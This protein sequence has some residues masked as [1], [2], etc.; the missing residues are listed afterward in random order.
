MMRHISNDSVRIPPSLSGHQDECGIPLPTQDAHERGSK[1]TSE[2]P[3]DHKG[4]PWQHF[5]GPDDSESVVSELIFRLKESISEQAGSWWRASMAKV[6]KRPLLASYETAPEE[7][8][9]STHEIQDEL[10]PWAFQRVLTL[11]ESQDSRSA[12]QLRRRLFERELALNHE[13]GSFAAAARAA[14]VVLLHSLT[15]EERSGSSEKLKPANQ[16]RQQRNGPAQCFIRIRPE[17][18]S[19]L[20]RV[21]QPK[22]PDDEVYVFDSLV[23]TVVVGDAQAN[24]KPHF[25]K[26]VYQNDVKGRQ[27]VADAVYATAFARK[28]ETDLRL[29]SRFH[30]Q[31]EHHRD[32]RQQVDTAWNLHDPTKFERAKLGLPIA[33]LVD[34]A[35]FAVLVEPLLPL[36]P[37]PVNVLEELVADIRRC[38]PD[39]VQQCGNIGSPLGCFDALDKVDRATYH[40]FKNIAGFLNLA[41]YPFPRGASDFDMPLPQAALW[42]SQVDHFCIFR[43]LHETLPPKCVNGRVVP[44]QRFRQAFLSRVFDAALPCTSREQHRA[45]EIRASK[46]VQQHTPLRGTLEALSVAARSL[47]L[48]IKQDVVPAINA[49]QKNFLDSH[50][51]AHALHTHGINIRNMAQLLKN[52]PA[53]PFK[54]AIIREVVARSAKHL[55]RLQVEKL[56]GGGMV[57]T[58]HMEEIQRYKV[59]LTEM[60]SPESVCTYSLFKAMEYNLNADNDNDG[61]DW[62][63]QLRST[64]RRMRHFENADAYTDQDDTIKLR[65]PATAEKLQKFAELREVRGFYPRVHLVAPETIAL[66]QAATASTVA[67]ASSTSLDVLLDNMKAVDEEETLHELI[68]NAADENKPLSSLKQCLRYKRKKLAL[69]LALLSKAAIGTM[70]PWPMQ[71]QQTAYIMLQHNEIKAAASIADFIY[72]KVPDG[73]SLQSEALLIDMQCTTRGNEPQDALLCYRNLKPVLVAMEGKMSLRLLLADLLLASFA[74]KNKRYN[75]AILH[76][77]RVHKISTV[78]FDTGGA[79]WAAVAALRLIA[80]SMLEV[81]RCSEAIII[82]QHTVRVASTNPELPSLVTHMSR[83]W[84]AAAF[85]RMGR[86]ENATVE[87][88]SMLAGLESQLGTN[89]EATMSALYLA[90]EV[91]MRLGCLSLQNPPLKIGGPSEM[92]DAAGIAGAPTELQEPLLW[93][94]LGAEDFEIYEELFRDQGMSQARADAEKLFL[95]LFRR[96]LFREDNV[97]VEV[98]KPRGLDRKQRLRQIFS[99]L[100]QILKLKLCSIPISVLR[101]LAHRIYVAC[102]AQGCSA[103]LRPFGL[104]E[105]EAVGSD[106]DDAK[107]SSKHPGYAKVQLAPNEEQ[108]YPF[109]F[110]SQQKVSGTERRRAHGEDIL[111]ARVDGSSGLRPA[112]EHDD[113]MLQ[114]LLFGKSPTSLNG[115]LKTCYMSY[116]LEYE[117]SSPRPFDLTIGITRCEELLNSTTWTGS[118]LQRMRSQLDFTLSKQLLTRAGPTQAWQQS[119]GNSEIV[120]GGRADEDLPPRANAAFVQAGIASL[121]KNYIELPAVGKGSVSGRTTWK[122]MSTAARLSQLRFGGT[123]Q[124]IANMPPSAY[125]VM[126]NILTP[127]HDS[128]LEAFGCI[129]CLQPADRVPFLGG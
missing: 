63:T 50:D 100:K 5:Q 104:M 102:V 9:E 107:G 78:C 67:G 92:A 97:L 2:I 49:L 123:K 30:A 6:A 79:H 27:A 46:F 10:A 20:W 68:M 45:T 125:G 62:G 29:Q 25:A 48:A 70:L 99:T 80:R 28:T 18:Y 58:S 52:G 32:L 51:I 86:L 15:L 129:E 66:M 121:E 40:K 85:A 112:Q 39:F 13:I 115:V 1:A 33:C 38:L 95:A 61:E 72:S 73:L 119:S 57:D 106:G 93:K 23:L 76:A 65:A 110:F 113:I 69:T 98:Y 82:L 116:Y 81:Q 84:L 11:R 3:L 109:S 59:D 41:D 126:G 14:A 91:K 54:D 12:S 90:A 55:F 34:Y 120:E 19:T 42:R 56:A 96:L 94:P 17:E 16:E 4:P 75:S 74:F 128:E 111:Y 21:Y 8:F 36:N 105:Q 47:E 71:L 22:F 7:V 77:F 88:Q 101:L 26:E 103:G 83:F 127:E 87:A 44:E 122:G 24:I 35:G 124:L 118:A 31:S 89:H 60:A 117:F 108:A 64:K 114:L 43:N 53:S 37:A